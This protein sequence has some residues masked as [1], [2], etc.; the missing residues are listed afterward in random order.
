MSK[1]SY[2]KIKLKW[3]QFLAFIVVLITVIRLEPVLVFD[4]VKTIML[5]WIN[6]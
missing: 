2:I 4:A 6:K 3:W 1:A 5:K